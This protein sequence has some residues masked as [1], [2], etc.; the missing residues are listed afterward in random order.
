MFS[1][2][3]DPKV[4]APLQSST[5]TKAFSAK[6]LSVKLV[7]SYFNGSDEDKAEQIK[8]LENTIN[9]LSSSN[10]IHDKK[11]LTALMDINLD[12]TIQSL[13]ASSKQQEPIESSKTWV[14]IGNIQNLT[15]TKQALQAFKDANEKDP[16]NSNAWKRQGHIYRQLKQFDKAESAF[17]K[18]QAIDSNTTINQAEY[19][20]SLASINYTKGNL[21]GAEESY[22]EALMI[23]TTFENNAGIINT[24][25]NLARIYI[26]TNQHTKA[27]KYLLT[28][29]TAHQQNE[30]TEEAVATYVA[31]GDL[32]HSI[33]QVNDSEIQYKKA[34]EI[35]LNN[36]FKDS[37]GIIYK[38]LGELA[39]SDGNP[40]LAKQYFNKALVL[41][42]GIE[43]AENNASGTIRPISM[44]DQFANLAIASRKKGAF[45]AAEQYHLKAIEI[46]TENNHTSGISSQKINLGFLYKAWKKP[47][48]ACETWKNSI[49]LLTR[50]NNYRLENVKTLIQTNCR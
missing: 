11:A 39:E 9:Y 36:S 1:P 45:D 40:E 32:Y 26:E 21:K 15:S 19:L 44:A 20:V 35:S 27:E 10:N 2:A 33:A 50:S 47:Q 5:K 12:S 17:R 28:A 46:Y 31:L 8:A 42:S 6:D 38:R 37:V 34:L 3:P 25:K 22:L 49:A 18:L 41:E 14:H 24:S 43:G 29:I 48:K 23:Y 30:Q 7:A 4:S 13:I 16:D